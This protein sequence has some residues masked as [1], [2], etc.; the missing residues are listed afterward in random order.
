M[1]RETEQMTDAELRAAKDAIVREVGSNL[2][3]NQMAY[4]KAWTGE[5]ED[6]RFI[7]GDAARLALN[8]A[9]NA[10]RTL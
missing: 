6:T 4:G 8:A 1:T 5:D 7:V 9:A 3:W 2:R 10:R